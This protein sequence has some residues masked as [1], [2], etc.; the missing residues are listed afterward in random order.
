LLEHQR[1]AQEDRNGEQRD[2]LQL[3]AARAPRRIDVG[4]Q[5]RNDLRL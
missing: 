3:S 1:A 5:R 4:R 2:A